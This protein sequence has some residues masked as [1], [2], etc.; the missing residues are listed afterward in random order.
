MNNNI[1]FVF[2]RFVLF[3]AI[4][5]FAYGVWTISAENLWLGLITILVSLLFG[6]L[7]APFYYMYKGNR[8]NKKSHDQI[9]RET[10]KALNK[11]K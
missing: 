2:A 11:K 8:F 10:L 5:M 3:G 7:S 9:V 4:F 1:K 6:L